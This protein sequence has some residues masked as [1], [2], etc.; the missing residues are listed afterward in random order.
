MLYAPFEIR[1]P[2][3][4]PAPGG[5]G[6]KGVTCKK[7]RK[8]QAPK[9]LQKNFLSVLRE[10]LQFE[11]H[12]C[13]VHPPPPRW[14]QTVTKLGGI[15]KGGG[16]VVFFFPL[17]SAQ[18]LRYCVPHPVSNCTSVPLL[19]SCARPWQA[20]NSVAPQ[21]RV[22]FAMCALT[23]AHDCLMRC[24]RDNTAGHFSGTHRALAPYQP[25]QP[26]PMQRCPVYT[27]CGGRGRRVALLVCSRSCMCGRGGCC[28]AS[29]AQASPDG[30]TH[31]LQ[32]SG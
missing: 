3:Q 4:S 15:S 26:P 1:S 11:C 12:L 27:W 7:R 20:P 5:G 31:R 13:V 28:C 25:G 30:R 29:L 2:F 17:S 10:L 23:R 18:G 6:G 9:A 22:H 32:E 24:G 16:K 21:P 8:Y 19:P 14:S